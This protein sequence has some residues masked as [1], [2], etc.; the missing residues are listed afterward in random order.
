MRLGKSVHSR[1]VSPPPCWDERM[2]AGRRNYTAEDCPQENYFSVWIRVKIIILRG[3]GRRNPPK[4][5]LSSDVEPRN[6]M[7]HALH[8]PNKKTEPQII[9]NRERWELA[10]PSEPG[11]WSWNAW[12]QTPAFCR[13]L[14]K[15][16]DLSG[17]PLPHLENEDSSLNPIELWEE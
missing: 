14:G 5:S 16:L 8:C 4:L 1:V 11:L 17:P 15:F 7:V 10:S 13:T 2:D 3:C 9:L 6:N 12:V